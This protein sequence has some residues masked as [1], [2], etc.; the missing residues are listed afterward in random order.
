MLDLSEMARLC[1]CLTAVV[2][3]EVA[4]LSLVDTGAAVDSVSSAQVETFM[5]YVRPARNFYLNTI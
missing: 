3:D 2:E 5:E 4:S 1:E